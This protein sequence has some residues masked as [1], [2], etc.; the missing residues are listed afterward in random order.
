MR[1]FLKIK[2]LILTL[3]I[4]SLSIVCNAQNHSFFQPGKIWYD[5]DGNPINAHAGGI[6]YHNSTYYWYG[7]IMIPGKRG[8]DSWVG[9]SCYSSKDLYNWENKG[10]AMHMED[11]PSHQITRGSKIE[12]PK[13]IYNEKTRK[14]VMWWHHDVNGQGHK[15]AMAGI[16]ISDNA[17]GPFTFV[18][19][20]RPLAGVLPFNISKDQIVAPVPQI[21]LTYEFNGGSLPADAD[22]LLIFKRDIHVGQMVRDMTIFVDED[23][24]AYHLYASEE[25]S[26]LHIAE[27]SEDYLGYTGKYVRVFPGR[28]MEAPTIFKKGGK[29]YII[30]SGCT[31]WAPNAARSATADNIFGPWK[32]LGN[33]AVGEQ[34]EI[35]FD[36]QGTF[37]IPV[38][39]KKDAFIFMA[40]RWK[41]QNPIDGRYVWLPIEFEG[42]KIILKWRDTWNLDLFD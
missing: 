21:T 35:T 17:E 41:P 33:P 8:S 11:H 3:V 42:E 7:Q 34:A 23:G 30:A 10:I 40:D 6:L 14:F 15:N 1:Y 20:F 13:V 16:A 31:G 26:T 38:V 9:V 28:F 27:L 29:Y 24:T 32:E 36:S 2:T 5:T 22:S 25:N 19:V 18:R 39:G 12:R 4:F 37:V